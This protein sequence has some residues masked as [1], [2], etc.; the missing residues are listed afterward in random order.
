[1][2]APPSNAQTHIQT[3]NPIL[4]GAY[5]A[6]S[7]TWC[8]GMFFP[9]LLLRDFGWSG[10]LIF[11][12]PNVLGA[13]AMGWFIKSRVESQRFVENHPAAVWW[14]ST[15]TLIFHVF[16]ILWISNFI[17]DTFP[18][19]DTY[20]AGVAA[21]VIAF[22]IVSSRAIR[23]GRAP[24]LAIVLL[25]FS[26]GVL[27]ATFALPDIARATTELVE[28]APHSISKSISSLWMIPLMTFGFI[29]CPYLDITFHHARQE[30]DTGSDNGKNG[31][32]AFT[33]GFVAFFSLM[34]ILT[35]RYA[36]VMD[37]ALRGQTYP[38]HMT[39]PPWLGA[40]ILTHILCQWVFTVRV[41]LDRIKTIPGAHAKQPM[42]FGFALV[43]GIAG[44]ISLKLP[45][46]SGLSGG[47]LLYRTFL[48]FYGLLFPTYML[49]RAVL[50][51][52]NKSPKSLVMMWG[53]IAVASPIFW[54]G[55]MERESIWLIPGMGIV[56]VGAAITMAMN[57]K[58]LQS[59]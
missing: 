16:W 6:C 49:Y 57:Q 13:A 37:S 15:I 19:P 10:F 45:D 34:I 42:L 21:A 47:E 17:R 43:S 22:S 29:L 7:W 14:F 27:V 9:V 35:T 58:T 25:A 36:G 8:I 52:Q 54:M 12:I 46:H 30:L 40:A 59:N 24:Q 18:L 53:A 31:R 4:W 20:L 33:I 2:S 41:H 28:A 51:R 38:N 39:L 50:A 26:V 3:R 11:A 48:S 55:F 1:M 32:L 44:M 56:L 5:L 23:F